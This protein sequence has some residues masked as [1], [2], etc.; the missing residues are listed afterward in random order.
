VHT[1]LGLFLLFIHPVHFLWSSFKV[2]VGLG[3]SRL[4]EVLRRGMFA[5]VIDEYKECLL[6]GNLCL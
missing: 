4:Y 1:C 2:E 6:T 3:L 5:F